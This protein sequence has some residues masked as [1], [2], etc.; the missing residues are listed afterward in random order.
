MGVEPIA[1]TLQGSVA[2]NGMP[3]RSSQRSVRELNPVFRLTTAACGRNTYRP[4]V[5]SDPGWNR[6]STFLHVAQASLPLDHGIVVSRVIRVGIE[7]TESQVLG[8]FALPVCVPDL[9][10]SRVRGSHPAVQAYE[11]RMG[12]GPPAIFSDEGEIRTPTPN[13]TTF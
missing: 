12:T 9:S 6:T 11:A 1:P 8:L 7:P 5:E 3:A 4:V 13:G 10:K 2:P